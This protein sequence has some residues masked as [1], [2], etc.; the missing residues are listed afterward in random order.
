MVDNLLSVEAV[1]ERV[2]AQV[3]P[4]PAEYIPLG[5]ALNR[6]VATEIEAGA[7]IP[8]FAN[9]SMD[10]YAVRA[11]E[12]AGASSAAPVVLA[13]TMDIPAGRVPQ[14]T[15]QAGAAAR[16]MTGAMLPDGADAVIPVES[17]DDDFRSDGTAKLP[18]QIAI[19]RAVL[20]GDYVR[21]VG[22]DIRV[23]QTILRAGAALRPQDIGVLASL[24]QAV[25]PVVRQ[26]RVA[27]LSSGDELVEVDAPLGPGQIRNSNSYM[28]DGLVREQG[29]IPQRI[30]TARDTLNDVWRRFREALDWQPDLILSTAGVSVGAH[31]LVRV[32][33]EEL[34]NLSLWR[35]NVRPG[36]PLAFGAVGVVPFFGLPGNPVSAS[37][38]FDIFVRPVLAVLAGRSA[39]SVPMTAATLAEDVRSDGRRSYLRVTL[40]RDPQNELIA[41]LTG[42]QSS[43]AL[44][45]MVLADGLLIV[46]EGVTEAKAGTR[47]SVRLLR[48]PEQI[49]SAG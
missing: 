5:D 4:L 1:L 17:T 24:G 44:M 26:P 37:V 8:P 45:S 9:S 10:G 40:R 25:V 33:V 7:N 21:P 19:F 42:T 39:S 41:H 12:V 2:L 48:S 47:Y 3:N 29:G 22:E 46:P 11:A 18:E 31:D 14:G 27:I 6:I 30:P 20:A 32:V 35:V 49:D 28:L 43:G 16:I 23:G 13:V 15:L 34:G 38:T 36:K